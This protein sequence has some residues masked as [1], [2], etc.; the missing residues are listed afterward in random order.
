MMLIRQHELDKT[1][2]QFYI[3]SIWAPTLPNSP[4]AGLRKC[5]FV[6]YCTVLYMYCTLQYIVCI[7]HNKTLFWPVYQT[8]R[9]GIEWTQGVLWTLQ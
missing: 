5:T 8:I 2:W 9:E 1:V 3:S 4:T 7:Q 6:L